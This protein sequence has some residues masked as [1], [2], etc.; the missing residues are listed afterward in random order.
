[1]RGILAQ[2]IGKNGYDKSEGNG[3][4]NQWTEEEV[5]EVQN[6]IS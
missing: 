3:Q 4:M 5:E 2:S 6:R 1:M